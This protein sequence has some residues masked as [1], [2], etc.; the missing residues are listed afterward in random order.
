[1]PLLSMPLADAMADAIYHCRCHWPLTIGLWPMP[2]P[3]HLTIA[4]ATAGALMTDAIT[5][6]I[7]DSIAD[8]IADAIV[9]ALVFFRSFQGEQV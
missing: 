2:W 7:A 5:D 9:D 4:D 6:A 1:M 3:V 8:V